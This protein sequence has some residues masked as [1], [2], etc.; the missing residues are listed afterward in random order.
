MNPTPWQFAGLDQMTYAKLPSAEKRAI[1]N[2]WY[3]AYPPAPVERPVPALVP[4][5]LKSHPFAPL[6]VAFFKENAERFTIKT[7]CPNAYI[8]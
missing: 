8:A 2:R 7:N 5:A 6:Y 4:E 3:A 1:L